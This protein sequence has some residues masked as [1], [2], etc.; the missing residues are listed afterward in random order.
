MKYSVH[1]SNTVL[2]SS[3]QLAEGAGVIGAHG[4]RRSLHDRVIE[5]E[6]AIA[7]REGRRHLSVAAVG[8]VLRADV[9]ALVS[10]LVGAV[11]SSPEAGVG[12]RLAIVRGVDQLSIGAGHSGGNCEHRGE[13]SVRAR[14]VILGFAA[15]ILPCGVRARNSRERALVSLGRG[16]LGGASRRTLGGASRGTRSGHRSALIRMDQRSIE[17]QRSGRNKHGLGPVAV[18][19]QGIELGARSRHR[20]AA[21]RLTLDEARSVTGSRGDRGQSGASDYSLGARHALRDREDCR[22]LAFHACSVEGCLACLRLPNTVHAQ[23][24]REGTLRLRLRSAGDHR[25]ARIGVHQNTSET[26]C[27]RGHGHW[28]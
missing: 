10:V 24:V 22:E 12:N 11:N 13:I 25:V 28:V 20:I 27:T 7:H 21:Q 18:S 8:V 4:A 9:R 14:V 2:P 15:L 1:S 6:Q 17:T 16:T 19:T 3:S 23:I 5:T 26:H